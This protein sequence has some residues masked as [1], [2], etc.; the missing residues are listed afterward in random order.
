MIEKNV[1]T[2]QDIFG[3]A[4]AAPHGLDDAGLKGLGQILRQALD[5]GNVVE[6]FVAQAPDAS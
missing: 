1:F 4:G 5:S 2:N 3:L 6:D